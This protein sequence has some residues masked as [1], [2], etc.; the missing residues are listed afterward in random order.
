MLHAVRFLLSLPV[1][2]GPPI[3]EQIEVCFLTRHKLVLFLQARRLS[4]YH[5]F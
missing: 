3:Q 2:Q 4:L 1:L 5:R